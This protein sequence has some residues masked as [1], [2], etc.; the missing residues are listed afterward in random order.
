ML[1]RMEDDRTRIWLDGVE[2]T[3]QMSTG[4]AARHAR[5]NL[6]GRGGGMIT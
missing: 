1:I 5:R 6:P 2:Q 4:T 3:V